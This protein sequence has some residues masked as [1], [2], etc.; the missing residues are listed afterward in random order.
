MTPEYPTRCKIVGVDG[1]EWRGMKI[2][3]PDVS[4]PH[5]GKEGLAELVGDGGRVKITLDNGVV[6]YGEE[7]WWIRMS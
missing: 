5:I 1:E 7:C 2:A 4:R 6:L 3:T